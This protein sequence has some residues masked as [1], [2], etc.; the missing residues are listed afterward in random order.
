MINGLIQTVSKLSSRKDTFKHL[1]EIYE[2][3]YINKLLNYIIDN[4]QVIERIV[5][6]GAYLHVNGFYKITL[7]KTHNG[8]KIRLHIWNKDTLSSC[9]PQ[10]SIH[11]HPWSFSSLV[12]SGKLINCIF[13]ERFTG[14]KY[15]K[16]K[17]S[18]Y[19]KE[20]KG[21]IIEYVKD[22]SLE[23]IMENVL[24]P[25]SFYYEDKKLLH[26]VSPYGFGETTSTLV[27]QEPSSY[28]DTDLYL[29]KKENKIHKNDIADKKTLE[30]VLSSIILN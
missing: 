9:S 27:I 1:N 18:L 4:D 6:N 26:R 7:G 29:L 28:S 19:G 10:L 24:Y 14:K 11:N 16:N 22:C 25:G 21:H 13:E 8:K 5:D 30:K 15:K 2:N 23:K 12:L 3:G 17:C 20:N